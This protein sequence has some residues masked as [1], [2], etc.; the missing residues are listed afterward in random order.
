MKKFLAIVLMG[1]LILA[2]CAR[3]DKHCKRDDKRMKKNGV[4]WKN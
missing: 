1:S 3:V 4:G 2:S